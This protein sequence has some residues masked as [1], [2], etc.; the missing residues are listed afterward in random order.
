MIYHITVVLGGVIRNNKES[1]ILA[2]TRGGI[3]SRGLLKIVLKHEGGYT[4]RQ[5]KGCFETYMGEPKARNAREGPIS[6]DC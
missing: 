4:T 6:S 3:V 5:G 2:R 1:D